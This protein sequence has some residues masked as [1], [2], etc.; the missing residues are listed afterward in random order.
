MASTVCVK[1]VNFVDS[2][3]YIAGI[4]IKYLREAPGYLTVLK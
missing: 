4:R 3:V 2:I 1:G